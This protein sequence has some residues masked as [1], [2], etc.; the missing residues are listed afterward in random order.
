MEATGRALDVAVAGQGWLT[1]QLPD[2]SEAYTRNGSLEVSVN[3]VLQSRGGLPVAGEGGPISIPPDVKITIAKDGTVSVIPRSDAQTAVNAIGRIKLVNPPEAE[4][5]RGEDGLFRLAGGAAADADP[6]VALAP[7]FLEGSNVN[8][9]E[10]MVTMIALARVFD[11]QMKALAN[12]DANDKAAT[13]LIA[14]L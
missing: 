9:I 11:M 6:A 12:A 14:N 1:L 13:Q 2:G 4:L 5:K 7:G 10:Q 8:A 3:G